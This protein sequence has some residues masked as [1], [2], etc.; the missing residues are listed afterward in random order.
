MGVC[1]YSQRI[2]INLGKK[3]FTLFLVKGKKMLKLL[4]FQNVCENTY[5]L[6]HVCFTLRESRPQ[7]LKAA[8]RTIMLPSLSI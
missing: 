8:A 2:P 5:I 4:V 3:I 7:A 6:L 1:L